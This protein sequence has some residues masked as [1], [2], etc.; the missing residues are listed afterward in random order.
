M[1]LALAGM[2]ILAIGDSHMFHLMTTLHDQLEEA[3]AAV[4]S[5]AMCGAT[6]QDWLSRSTVSCGRGEHHEKGAA[7]I[8]YK[9]GPTYGIADLI[10]KHHPNLVVVELGD[11]MEGYSSVAPDHSW[12]QQQVHSLT[13]KIAASHISC[14]W[15][16]PTWGEDKRPYNK[17]VNGTRDISQLLAGSVAPCRFVD[18]TTFARPGEWP[19]KDGAHLEPDGYRRWGKAAADAIIR[20]KSQGA[21]TAPSPR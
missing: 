2:V 14:V 4:H 7:T 19:T 15:V 6:A 8:D 16:G 18:S 10:E 5:Y 20:L 11:V 9:L 3:G 21:L 17:T 13:G 12:I 1:N